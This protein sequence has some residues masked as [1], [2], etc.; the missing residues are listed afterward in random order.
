[1]NGFRKHHCHS[2]GFVNLE[3]CLAIFVI[4]Y[5][6]VNLKTY[7]AI[8]TIFAIFCKHTFLL[9]FGNKKYSEIYI[10]PWQSVLV[11]MMTASVEKKDEWKSDKGYVGNKTKTFP[12]LHHFPSLSPFFP[13]YQD[14]DGHREDGGGDDHDEDGGGIIRGILRL[15]ILQMFLIW[16]LFFFSQNNSPPYL[17]FMKNIWGKLKLS[18]LR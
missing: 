8:F 12:Q 10:L 6:F 15:P 3:V 18:I 7:L 16:Q 11:M 9:L 4:S 13:P 14:E 2:Y 1:M 17:R 5:V